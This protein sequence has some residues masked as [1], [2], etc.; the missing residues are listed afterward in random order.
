MVVLPEPDGPRETLVL[1]FAEVMGVDAGNF[2]FE[3]AKSN[4]SLGVVEAELLRRISPRLDDFT[5]A[6]DRGVWIRSYLAH[7]VLVPRGGET[8]LPSAARIAELAARADAAIDA[9]RAGGYD[10]VGDLDRL[11]VGDPAGP[12]PSR[13]R[14][15]S[16][17]CSTPRSTRSPR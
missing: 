5:S 8:F 13:R 12:P 16:P 6:L 9:V 3:G 11:R 10:V 15:R 14:S 1:R 4:S 7:E 17:S 2:D